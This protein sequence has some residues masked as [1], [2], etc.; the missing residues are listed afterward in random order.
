[1]DVG[2]ANLQMTKNLK[3]GL[4]MQLGKYKGAIIG[5]VSGA[6]SST[7]AGMIPLGLT[8]QIGLLV[9]GAG[10]GFV[11]DKYVIK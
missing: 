4:K 1:M 8:G 6:F 3:R 7:V 2:V 9:A 5:A 11:L 10:I